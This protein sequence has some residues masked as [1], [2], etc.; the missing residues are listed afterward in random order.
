MVRSK[1]LVALVAAATMLPAAGAAAELDTPEG[2]HWVLSA[3]AGEEDLVDVSRDVPADLLLEAGTASGNGG[4]NNFSTS[5]QLDGSTLT[6]APEMAV[7]A[8]LCEGEAQAVEDAY[9]PLMPLTMSWEFAD[10]VLRLF[11][12]ASG[13]LLEYSEALV[14]IQQSELDAIL[15]EL[16][17]L[18]QRVAELEA[19]SPDGDSATTAVSTPKAPKARGEVTRVFPDPLFPEPGPNTV[20]WRDKADNEDGYRVYIRRIDCVLAPGLDP[21][22]LHDPGDFIEQPSRWIRVDSVPANKTRYVV[23]HREM[24]DQLPPQTQP[25]YGRGA[26]YEVSVAAHNAAGKSSRTNVG[27]FFTT[28]EY[29]CP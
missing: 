20:R 10:G 13:V 5:Y 17:S 7:T 28:P 8:R 29:G 26:L 18:Q 27:A 2:V 14:E 6:I 3:H 25:L 22:E 11:D 15:A 19:G 4:C 23:Q 21:D 16:A 1:H 24:W 9:L 12:E